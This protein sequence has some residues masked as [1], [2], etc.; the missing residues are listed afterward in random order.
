MRA[1]PSPW[2]SVCTTR[3]R[4]SRAAYDSAISPDSSGEPSSTTTTSSPVCPS[5]SDWASTESRQ[6]GRYA[7]T[8]YAGTTTLS[9]DGRRFANMGA[10]LADG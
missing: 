9:S 3:T 2:F 4:E 5:V 1:A 7:A 10:T 6:A 8:S